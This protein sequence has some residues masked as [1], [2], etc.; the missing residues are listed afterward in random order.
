MTKIDIEDV[1]FSYETSNEERV[2]ALN[3]VSFSVSSG[4][5]VMI[6]GPNGSGKTTLLKLIMG[7]L[8]PT[9]GDIKIDGI[10]TKN[11]SVYEISK[12]VGI[13]FQNPEKQFFA[14]TVREEL[15]FGLRNRGM[16]EKEIERRVKEVAIRFGLDKYLDKSP[17]DLSGGEKRRLSIASVIAL[18]PTVLIVDEPTANLDYHYR[19]F[20]VKILRDFLKNKEKTLIIA[21]HDIDFGLRVAERVIVLKEGKIAWKGSRED[22]ILNKERLQNEIVANTFTINLLYSL[23]LQKNELSLGRAIEIIERI[24]EG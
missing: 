23:I 12:K 4:D 11:L 19:N 1:Y 17:F 5:S 20:M 6:L 10:S 9:K 13:I 24:S 14:E 2:Y 3:G 15:A 7:L 18:E 8:K 21:T 22:L 16:N